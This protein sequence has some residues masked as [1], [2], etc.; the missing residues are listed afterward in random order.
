MPRVR[1]LDHSSHL[2]PVLKLFFSLYF[3]VNSPTANCKYQDLGTNYDFLSL[4]ARQSPTLIYPDRCVNPKYLKF[5]ALFY[6][7]IPILSYFT[8]IYANLC[9]RQFRLRIGKFLTLHLSVPGFVL[10]LTDVW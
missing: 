4:Q 6:G 2:T 7:S 3:T 8:T 1:K 9:D 10:D 5:S